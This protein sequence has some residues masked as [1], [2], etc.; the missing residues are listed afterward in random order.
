MASVLNIQTA[1]DNFKT[2]AA[3]PI[4]H[5]SVIY[6]KENPLQRTGRF[7]VVFKIRDNHTYDEYALR[8]LF[9]PIHQGFENRLKDINQFFQ[10]ASLPYFIPFTY[11]HQG[12][13]IPDED[14]DTD[15]IVM[16]WIKGETLDVFISRNLQNPHQLLQAADVFITMT[17]SLHRERVS[18]GDLQHGNIIIQ[19][20]YGHIFIYLVDYD[21][22]C[23]PNIEG[24]QEYIAGVPD[25]Q[26]PSRIQGDNNRLTEKADYFSELII[27]L[28]LLAIAEKPYLWQLYGNGE[29]LLFCVDD[30]SNFEQKTIFRELQ[31]CSN[32]VRKLTDILKKYLDTSHYTQ[33]EPFESLAGWYRHT[34]TITKETTE[35]QE[36]TI[37]SQFF[38]WCT[39]FLK[40]TLSVFDIKLEKIK[41]KMIIGIASILALII[42]IIM[43]CIYV[44]NHTIHGYDE[45]GRSISYFTIKYDHKLWFSNGLAPVSK[46]G[47]W[48]F[49]NK[50]GDLVIPIEYDKVLLDPLFF[51]DDVAFLIKDGY[52]GAVDRT[53]HEELSFIYT[54]I[55]PFKGNRDKGNKFF[56]IEYNNSW[57]IIDKRA[58]LIQLPYYDEILQADLSFSN[59]YLVRRNDLWGALN[60]NHRKR[61]IIPLKYEKITY[62]KGYFYAEYKGKNYKMDILGNILN[63]RK[64]KKKKINQLKN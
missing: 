33:L 17:R 24:Q 23:F 54:R 40:D 63:D 6:E 10:Q 1:I 45:D 49:I 29:H 37:L 2:C 20:H 8:I 31:Q 22:I 34:S 36:K 15:V 16:R 30:F 39:L 52:L 18:H 50:E 46:K 5:F 27:Y 48:G 35:E 61:D 12:L 3:S 62:I 58:R 53:G 26:H 19:E 38:D 7:N 11:Y 55:E 47:K 14:D 57:G 9:N 21:S 13:Y 56:K 41:N 32:K 25:Y 59:L 51:E 64:K 4:Q 42:V 28:S 44:G 43:V 60:I